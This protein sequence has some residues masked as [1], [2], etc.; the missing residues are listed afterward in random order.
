VRVGEDFALQPDGLVE[1]L[2]GGP[3]FGHREYAL[4][5]TAAK[6]LWEEFLDFF[7]KD[8]RVLYR[9]IVEPYHLSAP[10]CICPKFAARSL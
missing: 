10:S 8:T 5:P 1:I 7:D 2:V 6:E 3:K 4:E 9:S